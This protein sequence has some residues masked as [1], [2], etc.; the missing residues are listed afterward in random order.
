MHK[1]TIL[2]ALIKLTTVY[3]RHLQGESQCYK[4]VTR[5]KRYQFTMHQLAPFCTMCIFGKFDPRQTTFNRK[6]A[7]KLI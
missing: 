5:I 3:S 1:C 4:I 2:T 6:I 7:H